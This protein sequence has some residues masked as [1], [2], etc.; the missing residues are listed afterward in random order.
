MMDRKHQLQ[1]CVLNLPHSGL[2]VAEQLSHPERM[3]ESVMQGK[4]GSM[5]FTF[6]SRIIYFHLWLR[7]NIPL[8]G[9]LNLHL[10]LIKTQ[11]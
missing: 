9:L 2:P 11:H 3:I 6:W 1:G 7:G 5:Y 8:Q 10:V 4:I